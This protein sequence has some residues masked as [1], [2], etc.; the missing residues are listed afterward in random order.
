MQYYVCLPMVPFFIERSLKIL[1]QK[2]NLVERIRNLELFIVHEAVNED[3]LT[4]W[5]SNRTAV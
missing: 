5:W 3:P 1:N 2:L 4:D